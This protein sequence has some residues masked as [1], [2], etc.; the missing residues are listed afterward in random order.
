MLVLGVEYQTSDV[1]RI[2]GVKRV[3]LQTWL[4]NG[5]IIPSIKK[6]SGHGTRNIFSENDLYR[7]VFFKQAVESGISRKAA[8]QFVPG[9][10]ELFREQVTKPILKAIEPGCTDKI[11]LRKIVGIIFFRRDGEVISSHMVD[12]DTQLN[13][14]EDFKQC[15]DAIVLNIQALI[16]K[17]SKSL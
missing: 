17:V 16:E 9:M 6:A 4:S 1:E 14:F 5:W 12:G 10:K 3:R 7:I 2:C 11:R 8:G 15:D 13:S